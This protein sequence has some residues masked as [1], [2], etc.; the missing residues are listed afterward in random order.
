M[1]TVK[2]KNQVY[3]TEVAADIYFPADF[4]EN[5]K[6]PTIITSHPIG[7]SKEQTSGNIYGKAFAEAGYI[8]IA[9]NASFQGDS[10]G[11][12]RRLEDP[13]ARVEDIRA[14]VDY[15]VTLPYVDTDRIGCL[16]ICGSGGYTVK[17][18]MTD[19]RIK[20]LGT[21]AGINFGRMMLEGFGTGVTPVEAL[22][23]I[24]TQRTAEANGDTV[25]INPLLPPSPEDVEKMGI[26]D[27]DVVE[28]TKYYKTERGQHPNAPTNMMASHMGAMY[29]FDAFYPAEHLMTQPLLIVVGGVPGSF[30]SYRDGFDLLNRAKSEN[31]EIFVIPGACH[32]DL[33]WDNDYTQ[34]GIKK[35]I[36]FYKENL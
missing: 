31:K 35:L 5:K 17:A 34:Q 8:A 22:Q 23:G 19:R 36:E 6:Y 12:L 24:S 2:F 25:L 14:T 11:E 15:L 21:V 20:V 30:G 1:T 9:F 7:S 26:T 33:Y 28:A 3:S 29:G 4:D 32:Y 27:V 18:A 10:S 16:G 13:G